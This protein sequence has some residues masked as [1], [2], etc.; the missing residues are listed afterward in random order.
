[1]L[2]SKYLLR[3]LDDPDTVADVRSYFGVDPGGGSHP[4]RGFD[5]LGPNVTDRVTAVDLLAVQCLGVVVPVR[6]ALDL[7][8][9]GLGE[10]LGRLLATVPDDVDLG[11]GDAAEAVTEGSAADG[12]WSLLVDHDGVSRVVADKILA[13]KRP[14]LIPV[15]DQVV[16]CALGRP[17]V[18]GVWESLDRVIRT[19]DGAVADRLTRLR[20]KAA[21]GIEVAPLRLLDV[22]IWMRHRPKH[23]PHD[24]GGGLG[25]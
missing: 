2:S 7:L 19:S 17:Q 10:D 1:M 24:C 20:E 3:L 5:S 25:F 12:A 22:A 8:E 11:T 6:P 15:W 9:G 23:R 18:S 21:L 16:R 13:R 4:G 14:R